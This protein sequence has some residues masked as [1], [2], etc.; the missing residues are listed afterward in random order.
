MDWAMTNLTIQ[1]VWREPRAGAMEELT[2][3]RGLNLLVGPPN[4]GK[5]KWLQTLDF[6][7]GDLGSVEAALGAEVAAGYA[8]LGA[9]VVVGGRAWSLERRLE[10]GTRGKVFINGN[11]AFAAEFSQLLLDE[12]GI[13]R[14]RFPRGDPRYSDWVELTWRMLLRHVY[15]NELS[16]SELAAKQFDYEQHAVLAAFLNISAQLYPEQN[17]EMVQRKEELQRLEARRE[18]FDR[19]LE[20]IAREVLLVAEISVTVTPQSLAAAQQ[21][22][23]GQR[24]AGEERKRELALSVSL[25]HDPGPSATEKLGFDLTQ[26][27]K[28]WQEQSDTLSRVRVNLANLE[29]RQ[30]RLDDEIA[31]WRRAEI[32]GQLLGPLKVT[33]CPVCDRPVREDADKAICYLCARPYV[34]DS[35][36]D[37]KRRVDFER[38]QLEEERGEL[39]ALIAEARTETEGAEGN[40]RAATDNLRRLEDLLRPSYARALSAVPL[41]LTVI[42]RDLGRLDEQIRQLARV[43][44]VLELR[45][46]LSR[47]L[48]DARNQ[49][50]LLEERAATEQAS[51]VSVS[52]AEI[53]L[54]D[55]INTY[56][57]DLGPRWTEPAVSVDIKRRS[58]GLKIGGENWSAK[59][60]A[61]LRAFFVVAYQFGLLNLATQEQFAYPG[62]VILDFPPNLA[63]PSVV[64]GSENYL[65]EPFSRLI[66]RQPERGLQ[67]I[68]AGGSDLDLPNS[69]RIALAKVWS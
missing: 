60:G 10:Q 62:L 19:T 30:R 49:I 40:L 65:L 16:W 48:E 23:L 66:A 38:A 20:E 68:A 32:A 63:E 56:L 18:Q 53:A 1:R 54:A 33:N 3:V 52:A 14:F 61:T 39:T 50:A 15:R 69:H 2:F 47:Q 12:L 4:A 11:P 36:D 42:D 51:E 9:E 7:L 64:R 35:P 41:E 55:G 13:R 5:S 29:S 57:N 44:R 34:E 21:R 31:S 27:R 45:T 6:V 37:S 22:L 59:L 17:E 26:A 67:V 58:F 25:E 24:A 8:R 46:S 43:E 28:Q